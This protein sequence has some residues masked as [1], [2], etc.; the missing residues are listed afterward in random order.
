[1]VFLDMFVGM[2]KNIWSVKVNF[3]GLIVVIFLII[4]DWEVV[5]LFF[6]IVVNCIVFVICVFVMGI[7][8]SIVRIF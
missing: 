6:F 3:V 4:V 1:M 8:K 2:V 5:I 7:I